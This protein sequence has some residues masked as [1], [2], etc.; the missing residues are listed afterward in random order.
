MALGLC[1]SLGIKCLILL[2]FY[3]ENSP[4]HEWQPFA[5]FR[6]K[7]EEVIDHGIALYFAAPHSFTG[8]HLLELQG[9]GG[10]H[11]FRHAA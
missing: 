1:A 4:H 3:L 9:H 11:H 5:H 10:D 8:E 6:D 7:Q 2:K